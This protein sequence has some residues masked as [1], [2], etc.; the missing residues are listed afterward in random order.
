RE[1]GEQEVR[2]DGH[3]DVDPHG[4]GVLISGGGGVTAAGLVLAVM[5]V[6]SI[7]NT[8]RKLFA[9]VPT[10]LRE[11]AVAVGATRWEVVR[12]VVLPHVRA[13]LSG[14]VV[15]GLG[16]AMGEAMAVVLLIGN[17][18]AVADETPS[19]TIAVKLAT[20]LRPGAPTLEA[21][22]LATLALVLL[23]ITIAVRG[24]GHVLV[25]RAGTMEGTL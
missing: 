1:P 10:S 3:R 19:T 9:A 12:H 25:R 20:E 7:S 6:P 17:R 18:P 11:A 13:A 22:S 2:G 24:V 5:L 14:A 16:R 15:L 8:A 21:S 23:V 4:V